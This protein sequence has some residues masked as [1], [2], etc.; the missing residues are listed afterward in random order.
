[1]QNPGIY[2]LGDATIST[3][4][5]D[6][7]IT[8]GSSASGAAQ[9]FIDRL[10]GMQSVVLV[11]NFTWG[12]GGTSVA[13]IIQST[14]DGVQWFDIARFDFTTA[15]AAKTATIVRSAAA[16]A[17][18]ASLVLASEGVNAGRLGGKL[19]AKLTTLGVYSGNTS[20]SIRA[21]VA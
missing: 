11:A 9:A 20:I 2:N 7:V 12:S 21:D 3:A 13:A 18:I 19:R 10:A 6:L 15:S 16:A 14:L 1:M 4:V 5:T 8:A 17:T